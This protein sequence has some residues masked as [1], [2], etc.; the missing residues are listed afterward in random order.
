MQCVQA[1]VVNVNEWKK[2]ILTVQYLHSSKLYKDVGEMA[3]L[4]YEVY[5][6]NTPPL[7]MYTRFCALLCRCYI[8]SS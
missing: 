8:R 6:Y 2:T 4:K 7:E 3:L 1:Y 5:M